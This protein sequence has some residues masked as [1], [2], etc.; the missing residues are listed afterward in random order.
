MLVIKIL[1]SGRFLNEDFLS[2]FLFCI[3]VEYNTDGHRKLELKRKQK[4]KNDQN[5]FY[6][7][8]LFV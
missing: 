8:F 6:S 7:K 2:Y 5:V 3:M 4:T 1:V